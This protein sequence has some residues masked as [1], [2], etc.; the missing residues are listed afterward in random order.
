MAFVSPAFSSADLA[1]LTSSASSSLHSFL[2]ALGEQMLSDG[3]LGGVLNPC[4]N[5]NSVVPEV[6]VTLNGK[7]NLYTEGSANTY[8]IDTAK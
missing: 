6:V 5:G 3:R 8:T 2:A 7:L 4:D 1:A